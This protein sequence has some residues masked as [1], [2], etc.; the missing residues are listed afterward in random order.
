M[1]TKSQLEVTTENALAELKLAVEFNNRF[2][3]LL[4]VL[5]EL[6]VLKTGNNPLYNVVQRILKEKQYARAD[7]PEAVNGALDY[8]LDLTKQRAQTAFIER[9]PQDRSRINDA[10]YDS[11][12]Q[13]AT[14]PARE[15]I[16]DLTKAL[17]SIHF[18]RNFA[19]SRS[20]LDAVKSYTEIQEEVRDAIP[21]DAATR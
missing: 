18:P 6:C 4:D 11:A 9:I 13:L 5:R 10:T 14:Q 20:L 8:Y 1:V 2:N 7:V 21:V 17:G 15:L 12:Y 3:P 19:A 16:A